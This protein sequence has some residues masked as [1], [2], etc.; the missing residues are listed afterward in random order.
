MKPAIILDL[1]GTAVDSP[2]QKLPSQRLIAAVKNL[3]PKYHISSATGR[4]WTY[5]KS[6]IQALGL[7]DPCI[8]SAG[9]QICDPQT[10]KI[11]WQQTIPPQVVKQ[12]VEV[13]NKYPDY[14]MLFNDY[15]EEEYLEGGTYPKDFTTNQDVYLMESIFLPEELSYKIQ[16]EIKAID[17]VTCVMVVAQKPGT[18]DL[19]I[20]NEQATKEHA[21]QELLKMLGV[22][23]SHTTGVGDGH[24]D[25]DVFKAVGHKVAMGNAVPELKAEADEV[26]GDV[27]DDGLA[28][29]M[30]G[31]G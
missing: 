15:V 1:D 13:L 17:G 29:W 31:L 9:T 10:G 2:E 21:V 14:K 3:L 19:H 6:V 16:D 11:L 20:V 4:N 26:I 7:T 25:L 28:G 5:G 12:V 22:D 27:K 18:R 30:E 23:K 8:I 24:N